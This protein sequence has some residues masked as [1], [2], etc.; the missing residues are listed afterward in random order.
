MNVI[1]MKT[2]S[3]TYTDFFFSK[4]EVIWILYCIYINA[5]YFFLILPFFGDL[6]ANQSCHVVLFTSFCYGT[7]FYGIILLTFC[8]VLIIVY[9]Y[10]LFLFTLFF[11]LI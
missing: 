4:K 8:F 1:M 9:L 3:V 6:Y 2:Y 10:F 7:L 5:L 11:F